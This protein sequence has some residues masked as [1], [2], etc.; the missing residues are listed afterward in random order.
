MVAADQPNG[1]SVPWTSDTILHV[2]N[3]GGANCTV[4]IGNIVA[5]PD[6]A[7]MAPRTVTV[8]ASTGDMYIG[9]FPSGQYLQPDGN[10]YI[11]FSSPAT[12]VTIEAINPTNY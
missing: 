11:D 6:G 8:T 12:G 5:F 3:T 9:P 4:T 10:I 2:K 7:T 1:M